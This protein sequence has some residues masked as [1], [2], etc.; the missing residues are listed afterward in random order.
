MPDTIKVLLGGSATVLALVGYV[1]YFRDIFRGKTKPHAFSWLIW[2]VLTAIGYAGQVSD[3]AGAGAW[4]TGLTAAVCFFIFAL[5]V[6]RG[7]KNITRGDWLC[8]IFSLSAIPLWIFTNSPFWSVILITVIDIVGFLPTFRKS[9]FKP[10]EE[11]AVTYTLSSVKFGL[12][13]LALQNYS[14]ITVLYPASLVR[15]KKCSA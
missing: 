12:S 3:G 9:Y 13:I 7:E 2:G 5:A 11:T 4:V 6:F 14:V 1:P 8:L 15:A 10:H